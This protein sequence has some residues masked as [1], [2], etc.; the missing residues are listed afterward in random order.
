MVQNECNEMKITFIFDAQEYNTFKCNVNEKLINIFENYSNKLGK[1]LDSLYFLF[2][3]EKIDD[4]QKT[5][6]EIANEESKKNM[7]MKILVYQKSESISDD[8]STINVYFLEEEN[9]KKITCKRNE[10]IKNIIDKYENQTNL[11]NKSVIYKYNG[12]ALDSEKTFDNYNISEKDIFINVCKKTLIYIIFTYL[13]IQYNIECYK[14]DK[15]EDICSDFASKHKINKK[16]VIF[17][18]KDNRVDQNQTLN[19]FL[20]NNNIINNNEILIDVIDSPFSPSFFSIHKIKIIIIASITVIATSTF[21]PIVVLNKGEETDIPIKTTDSIIIPDTSKNNLDTST[22]IQDTS[23]IIPDTT[24]VPDTT[25][26]ISDSITIISD[27]FILTDDST[28]IIESTEPLII[29]DIG[30]KLVDREC[31]ID[32]FIKAT[33]SSRAN[34]EIKLISDE[35]N[36]NK[37]RKMIIDKKTVDPTKI[38]TFNE[39]G[40]HIIYF[41]F[42]PYNKSTINEGIG[43]FNGIE[44]LLFVEFS[45]YSDDYPDVRF[46]KIFNNCINLISVD[47]SQ[48]SFY[49]TAYSYYDYS[50]YY[51]LMDYMFNNC[52]SLKFVNFSI[53]IPPV[54][55]TILS[56]KFM[57][58]NCIS[59]TSIDLSVFCFEY[60][61]D[62]YEDYQL[63]GLNNMFSNCISL[64]I[65][66]IGYDFDAFNPVNISYMFYNCSSLTSIDLSVLEYFG[67]IND[68][69]YIFAYCS[70]LKQLNFPL[71]ADP[72]I[73]SMSNAFRNCTSLVSIK[74]DFLLKAEDMSYLFFGCISLT[75]IDIM[76]FINPDHIKYMNYMFYD[77]SSLKSLNNL[78]DFNKNIS[79]AKL[80]TTNLLDI[81]YMFSGCSSLISIDFSNFM[82]KNVINYKG[83]F[84]DCEK[85]EYIDISTFTH[86][87]LPDSNLSIFNDNCPSNGNIY[88]NY[89]FYFKTTIPKNLKLYITM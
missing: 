6:Y 49:E 48:I 28:S 25:S 45:N 30:Y 39:D 14:E 60:Q 89:D 53:S 64:N 59:L 21:V 34:E 84:Y 71:I 15:I 79:T 57:F 26:I 70:Q 36:L 19:Q 27:T 11:N 44:N 62:I 16:K 82:M 73:K 40:L 37:I 76:H 55:I 1:K 72:N 58:N 85:L 5:I 87:N 67:D 51:N 80:N 2:N 83:I 54:C 88:I 56:S 3:G 66:N 20:N 50:E 23:T 77:C 75:F 35:Y 81:S 10:K 68:I 29:C 41:S 69:S 8:D 63:S 65:I 31:L 9:S 17:K 47:L 18:H 4:F 52:I 24:K 7:E 33:Y 61:S 12:M 22:I 86:N 32:Y 13:N 38:Y 43:I 46:Y 42:I 74:L 78:F